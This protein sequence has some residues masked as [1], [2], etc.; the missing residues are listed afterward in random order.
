MIAS[1]RDKQY[2]LRMPAQM[3]ARVAK[4]AQSNG[5]SINT[6][7]VGAIM[8]TLE[9]GTRLD[10]LERRIEHLEKLIRER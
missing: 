8:Q 1:R 10:Q 4:L 2:M 7:I 3:H 9:R 6:E 5:H